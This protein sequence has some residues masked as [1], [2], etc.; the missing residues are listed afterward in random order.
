[1]PQA[2][3]TV[4]PT[5]RTAHRLTCIAAGGLSLLGGVLGLVVN[6]W[7]LTL[8][9][10]GGVWLIASGVWGGSAEPTKSSPPLPTTDPAL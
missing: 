3:Q 10:V 5:G 6:P 1:M 8:G 4:C 9:A 2:L 7:F